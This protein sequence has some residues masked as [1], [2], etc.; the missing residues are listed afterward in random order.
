VRRK[1]D[2]PAGGSRIQ[3]NEN[4]LPGC[5]FHGAHADEFLPDLPLTI[6]TNALNVLTALADRPNLDLMCTGG[7]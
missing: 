2:R 4:D 1:G 6:L 5:E 3:A 7:C